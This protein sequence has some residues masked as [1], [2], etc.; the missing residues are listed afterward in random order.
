MYT[1][2]LVAALHFLALGV[3]FAG[4]WMR[5]RGLRAGDVPAVLHGDTLWGIAAILWL[6]TGL[7][8]AFGGLEKG[9]DWYL[10]KP[11]F[12]VKM[13]LFLAVLLLELWPMAT[14]IRWRMRRA[15]GLPIDVS[16]MP[17]LARVNTAELLITAAIPFAAVAMTRGIHW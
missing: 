4:V 17:L 1:S 8:R 2:A 15:K 11:F 9:T 13:G 6:G 5:G 14:F 10:H 12:H 16:R 3:G 7:G